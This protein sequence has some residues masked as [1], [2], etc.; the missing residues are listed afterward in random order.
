MKPRFSPSCDRC[1]VK[2][3]NRFASRRYPSKNKLG[4]RTI[5]QL[6]NSVI[7][8]CRDLSVS[9][10]SIICLSLRLR[11]IIDLLGTDKLRYFA[12]PR[13]II[14]NYCAL[15]SKRGRLSLYSYNKGFNIY[16]NKYSTD[17]IKLK[18]NQQQNYKTYAYDNN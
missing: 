11:Q 18:I 15:L 5:K 4:D 8:K 7:A 12:P 9:R 16:C 17:E 14:A 1:C 2:M 10:R 3:A 6:L 13:P